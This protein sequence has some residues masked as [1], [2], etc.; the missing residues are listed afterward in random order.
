MTLIL[1]QKSNTTNRKNRICRFYQKMYS[2]G[3]IR[4]DVY[5]Y[6]TPVITKNVHK[7]RLVKDD[8]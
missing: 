6:T 7:C 1:K 2:Y 5:I 4:N 8:S 3:I